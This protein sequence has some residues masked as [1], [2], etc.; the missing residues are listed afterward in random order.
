MCIT[1]LAVDNGMVLSCHFVRPFIG[2]TVGGPLRWPLTPHVPTLRI[3]T[4]WGSRR[5]CNVTT[6]AVALVS[7]HEILGTFF[8]D[9]LDYTT[10][11]LAVTLSSIRNLQLQPA[12]LRTTWFGDAILSGNDYTELIL[13]TFSGACNMKLDWLASQLLP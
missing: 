6:T 9:Q 2:K 10:K 11:Q 13:I 7:S 8:L 12:N 5:L 3:Q 4:T 1:F